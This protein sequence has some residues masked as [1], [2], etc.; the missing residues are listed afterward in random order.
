MSAIPPWLSWN[1]G[2]RTF[3]VTAN[4]STNT[5]LFTNRLLTV[6]LTATDGGNS[7]ITATNSFDIRLKASPT[8][9]NPAAYAVTKG[10]ENT[11][12]DVTANFNDIDV[13]SYD[14]LT[15][16]AVENGQTD[17]PSWISF[18]TSTQAFTINATSTAVSTTVDITATDTD[19]QSVTCS[20]TINPAGN[21]APTL[22]FSNYVESFTAPA[23]A[24]TRTSAAA[25]DPDG[26]LSPVTI[27][28]SGLPSFLTYS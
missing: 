19:G 20:V 12:L 16:K 28:L 21:T 22:V 13:A 2:T 1:S 27:T 5:A 6:T 23:T 7:S 14:S 4:P 17:L 9:T 15:F 26:P 24:T 8:C 10:V 18:D 3:T 25:V 11:G